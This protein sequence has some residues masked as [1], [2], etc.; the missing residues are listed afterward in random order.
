[1]KEWK[2]EACAAS[3]ISD[4]EAAV[5][6]QSQ[7]VSGL[8]EV[9]HVEEVGQLASMLI[10]YQCVRKRREIDLEGD[11]F[12]R[13]A[14]KPSITDERKKSGSGSGCEVGT[15]VVDISAGAEKMSA[16]QAVKM[17]QLAELSNLRMRSFS[18][19]EGVAA[20]PPGQA[21]PL[22]LSPGAAGK[23]VNTSSK[24]TSTERRKST[25][26][27]PLAFICSTPGT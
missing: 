3:L 27:D 9:R 11:N 4:D 25:L 20:G 12:Q 16:S 21:S 24:T 8:G 19:P 10:K 23:L 5:P 14:D 15:R 13:K 18:Q 2:Q 26:T 17:K 7:G 22:P 6:E 1:M